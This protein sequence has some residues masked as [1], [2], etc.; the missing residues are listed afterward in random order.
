MAARMNQLSENSGI[1]AIKAGEK[2][3]KLNNQNKV[4]LKP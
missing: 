4:S 1:V 3:K 2:R